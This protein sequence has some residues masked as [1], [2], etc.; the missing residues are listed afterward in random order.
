MSFIH[1]YNMCRA[2]SLS[3]G[4][5]EEN[6]P[7]PLSGWW[8]IKILGD[9]SGVLEEVS[10]QG[11]GAGD[12]ELLAIGSVCLQHLLGDIETDRFLRTTSTARPWWSC[13]VAL[14]QMDTL[15]ASTG[16]KTGPLAAI[17]QGAA[18]KLARVYDDFMQGELGV[19]CGNVS[20]WAFSQKANTNRCNPTRRNPFNTC[21][22]SRLGVA[23]LH[24][25]G[26]RPR[27][28]PTT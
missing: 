10:K 7:P 15:G 23:A 5:T 20:F 26:S 8:V 28:H 9:C 11:L 4:H 19:G 22:A 1:D 17:V 27:R 24:R 25:T 6:F 21:G 2:M 14:L 13:A 3:H 16:P 18:T 12:L